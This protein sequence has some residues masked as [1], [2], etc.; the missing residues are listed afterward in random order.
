MSY[1]TLNQTPIPIRRLDPDDFFTNKQ[2]ESL[3]PEQ[4]GVI[5]S[6]LQQLSTAHTQNERDDISNQI[7]EIKRELENNDPVDETNL[8][9]P[10]LITSD[11]LS[12]NLRQP[13]NN[14]FETL[15]DSGIYSV[16]QILA[17]KKQIIDD[18]LIIVNDETI[19][20]MRGKNKAILEYLFKIKQNPN[21]KLRSTMAK[22]FMTAIVKSQTEILKL[23]T[24]RFTEE[25]QS[26]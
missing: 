21:D 9:D 15:F 16:E 3:T 19:N 11:S 12:K 22:D 17:A 4:I 13:I 8:H 10:E 26:F 23:N 25:L 2:I 6:L 24:T 14:M 20:S 7:L 18:I 5:G 1:S